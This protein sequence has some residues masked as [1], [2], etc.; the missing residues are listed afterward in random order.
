MCKKFKEEVTNPQD[1]VN[2]ID[3]DYKVVLSCLHLALTLKREVCNVMK[4]FLSF[5]IRFEKR[6]MLCLLLKVL[7]GKKNV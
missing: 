7:N 6:N 3:D 5:K 4:S 1:Q 2:L